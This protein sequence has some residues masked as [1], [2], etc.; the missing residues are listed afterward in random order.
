MPRAKEGDMTETNAEQLPDKA[1]LLGSTFVCTG[2]ISGQESLQIKGAFKGLIRLKNNTL[3]IEQ[4]AQVEADI[5]AGDVM[6]SG[7]LT[8]NIRAAGK[9][10]L[11]SEAS[12]RGDIT[13]ARISIKDGAQFRGSIKMDRGG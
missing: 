3:L 5:I 12:M 7:H 6:L 1:S 2:Q 13:A 9:V 4:G 8:G 10:Y 11:S